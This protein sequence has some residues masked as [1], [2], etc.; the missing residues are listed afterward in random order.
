LLKIAKGTDE[1]S[2]VGPT[3]AV[4]QRRAICD[5]VAP[6]PCLSRRQPAPKVTWWQKQPKAYLESGTTSA[7][8][9]KC[10]LLK[11]PTN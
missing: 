10:D 7:A 8:E 6:W 5:R 11:P 2:P 9:A 4:C 1:D 3:P